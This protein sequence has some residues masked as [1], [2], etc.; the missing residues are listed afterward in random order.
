MAGGPQPRGRPG[1]ER[2]GSGRACRPAQSGPSPAGDGLIADGCGRSTG[3]QREYQRA[4]DELDNPRSLALPNWQALQELADALVVRS[5]GQF[6]GWGNIVVF[7]AVTAARIGEVSGCC[8]GDIDTTTWRWTVRRQTTPSPGGLVDKGT[9]GKRARV[10]P[11]I[12]EI[13]PLIIRQIEAVDRRRDAR[14]FTGPR[15]GRVTT[16]VLRDATHWDEVVTS[17]GYEHLRRHNLRHTGL[18]W[19]AD[20]GVPVHHLRKIAGHGSLTTTQRYLHPDQQ[21]VT[22]AAT[23]LSRHING[24]QMGPKLHA[25]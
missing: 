7:C 4:E 12:E 24:S 5:A 21:A 13:R 17:L 25:L 23:P 16:A 20:A 18:T 6:L 22:D 2:Q 9:K 10:V 15:G 11:L 19:M 8:V 1:A 3:W 14:L